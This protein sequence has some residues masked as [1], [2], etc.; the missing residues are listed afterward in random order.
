MRHKL[1]PFDKV[2]VRDSKENK[3]DIDIFVSVNTNK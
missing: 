1:Q 2:L 3:W